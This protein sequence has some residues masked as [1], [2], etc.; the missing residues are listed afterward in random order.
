MVTNKRLTIWFLHSTF[1][2]IHVW[3]WVKTQT[4]LLWVEL[5]LRWV[6]TAQLSNRHKARLSVRDWT[7]LW[8]YNILKTRET[9]LRPFRHW[10]VPII[11]NHVKDTHLDTW[12]PW[13]K[14]WD[15]V[16]DASSCASSSPP[17]GSGAASLLRAIYINNMILHEKTAIKHHLTSNLTNIHCNM[18]KKAFLGIT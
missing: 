4:N 5:C 1:D 2:P 9:L 13:N 17:Q 8:S 18:V 14:N 15:S 16:R 11:Q 7:L 6:D 10:P 12:H 3:V